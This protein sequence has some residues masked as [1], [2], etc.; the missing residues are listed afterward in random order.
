MTSNPSKSHGL[1]AGQLIVFFLAAFSAQVSAGDERLIIADDFATM[2][3]KA[4][5]DRVKIIAEGS[6]SESTETH[7]TFVQVFPKANPEYVCLVVLNKGQ[8][9]EMDC[10]P[11][12]TNPTPIMY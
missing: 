8:I 5:V 6:R 1:V 2:S 9:L 12:K 11:R 10:F 7:L 3:S 4:V